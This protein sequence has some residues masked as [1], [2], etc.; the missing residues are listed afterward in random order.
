MASGSGSSDGFLRY[1]SFRT[2]PE[3]LSPRDVDF[4]MSIKY[5]SLYEQI[6]YNGIFSKNNKLQI[7]LLENQKKT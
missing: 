3:K 6:Y 2:H 5:T 7:R 4:F 1:T